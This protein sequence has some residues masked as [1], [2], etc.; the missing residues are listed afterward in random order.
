MIKATLLL[1]VVSKTKLLVVLLRKK[2]LYYNRYTHGK[3]Y[4]K[5]SIASLL[6]TLFIVACGG[7]SSSSSS[8]NLNVDEDFLIDTRDGQTYKTVKIGSQ[9]WM[10]ENLNYKIV[11]S[12]CYEDKVEN[13]DEY[14]RLYTWAAAMDSVG[15]WSSNG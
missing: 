2:T 5:K 14:G 8:E 3:R 4:V 7:D 6:L 10:A 11:N 15:K 1:S 13:C 12:S 9:T